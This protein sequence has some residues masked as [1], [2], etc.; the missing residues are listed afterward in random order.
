MMATP[1]ASD[2][3]A[4]RFCSQV[5]PNAVELSGLL[6]GRFGV[7]ATE[8]IVARWRERRPDDP[9]VLEAAADLLLNHGHGKS[10]N[11]RAL[12]IVELAV[13][14][15]PDHSGLR[16]SLARA[17]RAVGKN[18]Q[19]HAVFQEL[20]ERKPD[21][22]SA[23]ISVAWSEHRQ[24]NTDQALETL[25]RARRQAPHDPQPIDEKAKILID[26]GR[27]D[28]ALA[29][30]E[31]VLQSIPDSVQTYEAAIARFRQCGQ[32]AEAV[33]AARR[34]TQFFPRGAYLWLLLARTLREEPEFA[35]PGELEASLR[36]SIKLNAT[37]YESTDWLSILL[38]EQHRYDEATEL[39]RAV[40]S[41]MAD[42][43]PARGR[44]AW[45]KRQRGEMGAAINELAEVVALA[46]WYGWGWQRLLG[47]LGEDKDWTRAKRLLSAVPPLMLDNLEFRQKRL[48]LL[49]KAGADKSATE[50][51]WEML[52]VASPEDVVLHLRR[53]DV[54][55]TAGRLEEGGKVLRR[56]LPQALDNVYLRARLVHADCQEKNHTLAVQDALLVCFAKM[57]ESEWPADEVWKAIRKAG[58]LNEFADGFQARLEQ[59]DEPT[60]RALSLYAEYLLDVNSGG[61]LP[62]WLR[63]SWINA[64]TRRV[65]RFVRLVER[66]SWVQPA[67]M[68]K[69]MAA[70]NKSGRRRMVL[71]CWSHLQA[72]GL[73]SDTAA[74]AQAGNA[75]IN[76][77]RKHQARTLLADWRTRKGVQMWM[78]G[79]YALALPRLT[80]GARTEVTAACQEGL[81]TLTHDHCARYLAYMGAEA[82]VLNRDKQGLLAI[83][84]NHSVYFEKSVQ[85]GDFFPEWQRYLVYE[86]PQAVRLLSQPC[87]PGYAS[88]RLKL[89]AKRLWSSPTRARARRIFWLLLRLLL[90]GMVSGSAIMQWFR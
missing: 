10:A 60:P 76:M 41:Y 79:N 71:G 29:L 39:L 74:W 66:S 23:L 15:F 27:D 5:L 11:E 37:L 81:A 31:Q 90:I 82:C 16:L 26:A 12:E 55:Q 78:L 42:P 72:R 69:L 25:E 57:E 58:I 65:Q 50:S 38:C 22:G 59:G 51:E 75:L 70:L 52:L 61:Q 21:T 20:V 6:A 87:E 49:E 45:I 54:L 64:A 77:E 4:F 3:F 89:H 17:F 46:P 53:F 9:N 48:E 63:D 13:Q 1:M 43:S 33:E 18:P 35:A 80:R 73:D 68:A 44:L 47:W 7:A 2:R 34:G 88:L 86:V 30:V 85:K 40:E 83:W 84:Q 14:R 19:A 67:H 62:K 8:D 28:E 24:G 32:H 56:V 36:R